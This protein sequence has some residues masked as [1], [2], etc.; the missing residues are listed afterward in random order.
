MKPERVILSRKEYDSLW[1]K[2]SEYEK[3][4]K[5]L[6]KL[7]MENKKLSEELEKLKCEQEK[8]EEIVKKTES[9]LNSLMR[10]QADFENYRKSLERNQEREKTKF[11]VDIMRKLIQHLDDLKRAQNMLI[12]SQIDDAVKKGLAMIVENFE[13]LL[14]EYGVKPMDCEGDLFDPHEH[15]AILIEN[16]PDLPDGTIVQELEK[17][18]YLNKE[19]LRPS[20]VKIVRN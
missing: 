5:E 12:G 1:K 6:E 18:Y 11:I 14:R 19:I 7:N 13:K 8:N 15:E 10:L 16:N 4:T 20:R 9:Y 17:G 3:L 2:A